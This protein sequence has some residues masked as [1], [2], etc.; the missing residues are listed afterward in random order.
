MTDE[1]VSPQ[2]NSEPMNAASLESE[3][4]KVESTTSDSALPGSILP[5]TAMSEAASPETEPSEALTQ[6]DEDEPNLSPWRDNIEAM[7]MAVIMA[8]LL[9]YFLVEAYQIPSGSMQPTLIGHVSSNGTI[10]DR[11]LADKLSY[12]FRDP[13]RFEIVVFRYPLN[14]SK[15]FV[16]RLVGMPGEHFRVSGGDLWRRANEQDDWQIL[17]RPREVQ[18]EMWKRLVLLD[19]EHSDW[20]TNSQN[21]Q[22]SGRQLIARESGQASFR[23]DEGSIMDTYNHGYPDSIRPL[24]PRIHQDS[25]IHPVSDL[26]IE[27]EV[28]ALPGCEAIALVLTEGSRKFT[29]RVPGPAAAPGEVP[30]IR[31]KDTWQNS[32]V[33]DRSNGAEVAYQLPANQTVQI[34]AQN[35]DDLLQ[36]EIDGEII[37]SVEIEPADDQ[38]SSASI[39]VLGEGADLKDLMLYRD[40]HYTSDRAKV[41]TIEI[42]EGMY[43]M[44]GDNT[45]NSSD[46]REWTFARYEITDPETGATQILRGSHESNNLNPYI[47]AGALDGPILYLRDEWGERH[48]LIQSDTKKL[49]YEIAPFVPRDHILGRAFA[50]FWPLDPLDGIY[51]FGWLH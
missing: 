7:V 48:R 22:A 42:P 40:V 43:F 37:C 2:Q 34:A 25:G 27:A 18:T 23:P 33:P 19:P 16:K 39:V 45:Q 20:S 5:E 12:H 50:V 35:L 49:S 44:L 46:S 4:P 32:R 1:Q 29:F 31:Q 41:S 30:T 11:I 36:L 10:K 21:W 13:E 38:N 24:I 17:R 8:L 6:P 3:S 28:R 51:R 14:R 47:D 26:R 9:K 15:N